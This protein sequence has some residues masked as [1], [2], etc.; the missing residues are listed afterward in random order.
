MLTGEP[1]RLCRWRLH[2]STTA[3]E[4]YHCHLLSVDKPSVSSLFL[5]GFF[6]FYFL[7]VHDDSCLARVGKF[8]LGLIARLS[9]CLPIIANGPSLPFSGLKKKAGFMLKH[10]AWVVPLSA[11]L[12]MA[13]L[14]DVVGVGV[15]LLS[16]FLYT[17]IHNL[18][19]C[20]YLILT[21]KFR[22]WQAFVKDLIR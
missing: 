20:T 9:L 19:L 14:W 15:Q 13:L 7:S 2:W 17:R 16:S 21:S 6:P 3:A 8:L 11:W 1:S 18:V 5:K 10:L 22:A 12:L 4:L